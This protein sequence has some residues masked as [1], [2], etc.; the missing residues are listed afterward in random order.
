MLLAQSE[1]KEC[2]GLNKTLR[3]SPPKTVCQKSQRRK[4]AKRSEKSWP[5][6][7]SHIT[8][9]SAAPLLTGSTNHAAHLCPQ[10]IKAVYCV[11][12]ERPVV[13]DDVGAEE[14]AIDANNVG[15]VEPRMEVVVVE[16]VVAA[17]DG[18]TNRKSVHLV[19]PDCIKLSPTSE[20]SC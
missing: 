11:L 14:L 2:F 4:A 19:Q 12:R 7:F 9:A 17:V 10:Q 20:E 8:P 3:A 5:F 6:Q 1:S 15:P 13:V 18:T 16:A